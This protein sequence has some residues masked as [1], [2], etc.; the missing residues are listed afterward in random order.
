MKCKAGVGLYRKKNIWDT[1]L[2]E[3]GINY[4]PFLLEKYLENRNMCPDTQISKNE[5]LTEIFSFPDTFVSKFACISLHNTVKKYLNN[6][7]S[8]IGPI[9]MLEAEGWLARCKLGTFILA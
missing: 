6:N 5:Y 2:N 4:K 1:F 7:F 9:N 8:D 3:K